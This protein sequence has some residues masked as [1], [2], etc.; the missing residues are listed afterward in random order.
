MSAPTVTSTSMYVVAGSSMV[1]P[2]AISSSF[3]ACLTFLL[4]SASSDRLLIPLVSD[5]SATMTVSTGRRRR[6]Y[7]A[8]GIGQVVSCC[9]FAA[10]MVF[11][12]ANSGARSNA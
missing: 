8:R 4:I 6:R 3:L 7:T 9:A 2:A 11:S 5:A 1:T 12:S 10:A